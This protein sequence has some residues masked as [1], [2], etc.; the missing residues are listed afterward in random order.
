MLVPVVPGLIVAG[1]V[2]AQARAK[3]GGEDM[4]SGSAEIHIECP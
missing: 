2:M 4:G 3:V 1:L